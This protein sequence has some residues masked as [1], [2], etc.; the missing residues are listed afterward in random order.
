MTPEPRPAVARAF[1][2]LVKGP[3][4]CLAFVVGAAIVLILFFPPVGGRLFD[5]WVEAGFAERFE[6]RLE[7]GDAWVGSLYGRQRVERV[8]LRAPDGEEVLSARLTAPSLEG[9]LQAGGGPYGPVHLSVDL[10]RLVLDADGSTNLDRALTVRSEVE[11]SVARR[12]LRTDV[13]LEA[14]LVVEIARAR[15]EGPGGASE[16]LT[17]LTLTGHVEWAPD[18]VRVRLEG[19]SSAEQ[20]AAF[21]IEVDL[22]WS[23]V[24][25]GRWAATWTLRD[26][27]TALAGIGLRP[28]GQ[29]A[30]L[31]GARV[32]RLEGRREDATVEARVLDEGRD[33]TLRGHYRGDPPALVGEGLQEEIQLVVD[34]QHLD[35]LAPL[36][37]LATGVRAEVGRVRLAS[38]AWGLDGTGDL[39]GTLQLELQASTYELAP[40]LPRP[41]GASAELVPAAGSLDR[42]LAVEHG[43]LVF[44][45]VALPL[46]GGQ[47]VLDGRLALVSD[48]GELAARLE[49]GETSLELGPLPPAG[50]PAP[51]APRA[52]P[53][54]R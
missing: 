6:G 1:S 14:D 51:V 20:W 38:Y 42:Q 2:C 3:L 5:R 49:T 25:A 35:T 19:G 40:D 11:A 16:T 10:L 47:L 41:P 30:A 9:V 39:S 44:D 15:L 7:L 54:Q 28:L 52:P 13:P 23:L 4:G 22:W 50:V 17:D 12:S 53:P 31:A 18:Q 29:L 33:L 8:V 36:L 21:R 48:E 37:P 45:Q 26:A 46:E 27:P 34:A 32:D 24:R 43:T